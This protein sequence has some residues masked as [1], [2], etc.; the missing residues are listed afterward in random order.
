[1]KKLHHGRITAAWWGEKESNLD[2]LEKRAKIQVLYRLSYKPQAGARALP[3]YP[4]KTFNFALF[5]K[6]GQIPLPY[7]LGVGVTL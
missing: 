7:P 1:M 4:Q 2:L 3:P 5:G 6:K